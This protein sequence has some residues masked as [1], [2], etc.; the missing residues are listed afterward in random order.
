MFIEFS[1]TKLQYYIV[2]GMWGKKCGKKAG[3]AVMN[4]RER[5]KNGKKRR[6]KKYKIAAR[7]PYIGQNL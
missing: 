3:Q 2:G 1:P 4:A 7:V 6:A 5:R